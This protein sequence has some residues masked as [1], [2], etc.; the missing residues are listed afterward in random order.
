MQ[1]IPGNISRGRAGGKIVIYRIAPSGFLGKILAFAFGIIAL[2]SAFFLSFMIFWIIFTLVLFF[3]VYGL[4]VS[5][6]MR[7]QQGTV[8]DVEAEEWHSEPP[9]KAPE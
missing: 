4:W 2:V 3:L 8:I 1:E 5:R 7:R 6:R 9:P